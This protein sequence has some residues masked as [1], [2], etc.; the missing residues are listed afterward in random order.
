MAD[1]TASWSDR[2]IAALPYVLTVAGGVA[3]IAW[4]NLTFNASPVLGIAAG[5]LVG[6][7][8]AG[9]VLRLLD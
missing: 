1:R 3:G 5:A 6:R 9:L 8:L 7:L 4:T 2:V